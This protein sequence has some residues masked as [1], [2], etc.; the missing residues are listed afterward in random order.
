MFKTVNRISRNFTLKTQYI[1]TL[2]LQQQNRN[3]YYNQWNAFSSKIDDI[4]LERNMEINEETLK[5]MIDYHHEK[6][7]ESKKNKNPFKNLF[8]EKEDEDKAMRVFVESEKRSSFL[9][10]CI[11]GAVVVYFFCGPSR[12]SVFEASV[13]SGG[14]KKDKINNQ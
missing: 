4:E 12:T 3:L 2:S 13:D 8:T 11:V 6:L 9:M 7:N 5:K 1:T 14:P 10:G